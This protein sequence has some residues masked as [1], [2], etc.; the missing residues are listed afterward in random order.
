M[1]QSVY[2]TPEELEEAILRKSEDIPRQAL[3]DVVASWRRRL[4]RCIECD[5]G[6]FE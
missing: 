3:L 6:Y 4:E 2:R 5:G 1:M